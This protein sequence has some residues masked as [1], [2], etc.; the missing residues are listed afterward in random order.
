MTAPTARTIVRGTR[1]YH[2]R[3]DGRVDISRAI[4]KRGDT[5]LFVRTVDRDFYGLP[6]DV[7]FPCNRLDAE[8]GARC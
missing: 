5:W 7:R 4:G 8:V 1:R 3:P 2:V 6:S